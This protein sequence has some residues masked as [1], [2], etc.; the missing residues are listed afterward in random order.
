MTTGPLISARFGE[1]HR[2]HPVPLFDQNGDPRREPGA[3]RAMPRIRSTGC[4]R[5]RLRSGEQQ[6]SS[7]KQLL[8]VRPRLRPPFNHD[9]ESDPIDRDEDCVDTCTYHHRS[10]AEDRPHFCG[11]SAET[12]SEGEDDGTYHQNPQEFAQMNNRPIGISSIVRECFTSV[13]RRDP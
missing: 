13:V 2:T 5:V 11:I 8:L 12:P 3:S 10:L 6:R 4:S 9:S 1:Q 7:R